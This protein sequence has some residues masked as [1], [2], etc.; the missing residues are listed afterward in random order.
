MVTGRIITKGDTPDACRGKINL[1]ICRD[2][3]SGHPDWRCR[4]D[5]GTR[6]EAQIWD[7]VNF[8]KGLK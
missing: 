4:A 1:G 3:L 5:Y 2:H 6:M 7:L 8:I